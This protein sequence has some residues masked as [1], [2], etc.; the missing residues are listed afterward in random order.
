[1]AQAQNPGQQVQI[2]ASDEK[3]AG[4]Y[5]NMMQ[6]SH[7]REEFVLDFV[8]VLPP[9]GQLVSRILVSPAHAKRILAALEENVKKYEAQ[10]K[11]IEGTDSDKPLFGFKTE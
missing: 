4:Q 7:T 9:S 3:L 5:A 8:N 1:M 10:F 11:K 6:V 2:K